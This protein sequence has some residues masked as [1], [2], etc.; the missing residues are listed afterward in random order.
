[1]S[2]VID[3]APSK[4]LSRVKSTSRPYEHS[5]DSNNIEM[6]SIHSRDSRVVSEAEPTLKESD[7]PDSGWRAWLVVLGAFCANA[8]TVGFVN[9][10]G[11]IQDYLLTHQLVDEAESSVGWI[12]SIFIFMMLF[13]GI[14]TGPL[15]D[16]FGAEPLVIPGCLLWCFALMMMSLCKDYYQFILS[17][18]VLGG[19]ATSLIYNPSYTIISQWFTTKKPLAMSI[20]AIGS[21]SIGSFLPVVLSDLFSSL[22]YAWGIRIVGFIFVGLSLICCLTVK[23][24]VHNPGEISWRDVSIDLKSLKSVNFRWCVIGTVLSEWAFFL[25]SL[26]IVSYCR[27]VLNFDDK[28]SNLLL[29]YLNV[30]S[31]AGRFLAGFAAK[32]YGSFNTMAVGNLLTA[33]SALCVWI[34]GGHS[35]AG[36]IVFSVTFGMFSG[37]AFCMAPACVAQISTP[38]N[39]GRRYGTTFACV[40][41]AALTS[42]P[43]GGVL[44][45]HDYLGMKIVTGAAYFAAA[46]CLMVSRHYT[47]HESVYI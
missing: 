18:S 33:I 40:S 35:Y 44:T 7:I 5:L 6:S 39:F 28:Q 41:V 14:Q 36:I 29:V 23:S 37:A 30:S 27:T 9:S 47:P 17:L 4:S 32:S 31:I 42:L 2:E 22:G 13:W 11:T 10:T 43:I 8:M 19:L 24:R 46:I 45:G 34:P 3:K 1:M 20:V 25:P 12:F 26:Y 15:V 16:T 21:A 38:T